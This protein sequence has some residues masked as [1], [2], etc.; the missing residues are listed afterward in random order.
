MAK[1]NIA[2]LTGGYSAIAALNAAFDAIEA[3]IENTLSRD[4]T[5]PNTMSANLDMNSRKVINLAAPTGA[6]DAVRLVDLQNASTDN[7]LP[8]QT[9]NGGKVLTT[10]G[11]VTSWSVLATLLG[12]ELSAVA[13]RL[14]YFTSAS[15]ISLTPLSAF[16]RTLLDDV[17]AAAARATLGAVAAGAVGSTGITQNTGKLLGRTTASA[18][19]IEEITPSAH[20]IFSG[21]ALKFPAGIGP[22]P[23]AGSSIPAGWLE[24]NGASVSRTTYA[25]LF[26]A[27]GTTFGSA[28]GNSFNLPD[29]Q[30]RVPVGV[31]TG[32]IAENGT[33]GDVSIGS[34]TLAVPSNDDRWITGMSVLF[35]LSS[36]TITGLTSGNTYYIVRASATTVK[37]ASSLANA[38]NGTVVDLTAISSPVWNIT[39]THVARSLG[40]KGGNDVHAM[41]STELVSHNH[42]QNSHAHGGG[43]ASGTIQ[44]VGGGT[45]GGNDA[46]TGGAT[47]TNNPTGGTAAMNNMPP[48]LATKFII[49]I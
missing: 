20:F 29:M 37:L 6:A 19:A 8:I 13:D 22:L 49:S 23:Y 35:T 43:Q 36:G 25:D 18:G 38:Q 44:D 2:P 31:G 3:A 10:D 34:D 26:A 11:S 39:H 32:T 47:A 46:S 12:T 15:A 4:G 45:A 42:T 16:I 41:S 40:A 28:D 33:G 17:D 30:G 1:L 14:M 5:T 24:C 27:I 9:G 48:Y 7:P 21:G